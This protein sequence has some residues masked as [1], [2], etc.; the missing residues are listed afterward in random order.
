M[1]KILVVDDEMDLCEILRFN[2]KSEGY[3]VDI[4]NSAEE[5]LIILKDHDL[6]LLDVMLG[7]MSGYQLANKLRHEIKCDIPIIFLTAKSTEN[8]LLTGFSIGG[9]DYICKPFS[10]KEVLA[11][12]KAVF[13]RKINAKISSEASSITI[14][15][16]TLDLVAKTVILN[17]S[18]VLLTKKE[19][20][21]LNLLMRS[22][23][24]ILTREHILEQVWNGE[25]Y[26]LERTV[27][28]HITRLRKKLGDFG[29]YIINRPG[30]GYS[31]T[32]MDK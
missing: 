24:S 11:R 4:A 16:L 23:G 18:S 30:F 31:F 2:L 28:V 5:A 26:V 17:D 32:I 21:I 22:A 15:G 25:A 3:E 13:R 9:D 29:E 27:D 14:M 10:I 20:L 1:E 6:V 19:F 12:I 7:G 8:D